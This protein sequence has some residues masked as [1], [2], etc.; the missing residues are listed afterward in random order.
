MLK[1]VLPIAALLLGGVVLD[2]DASAGKTKKVGKR[3]KVVR[4]ER[5]R[6]ERAGIPRW[7][8][9]R[10]D[11]SASCYGKAPDMG[12]VGNVVDEIGKKAKVRV[13]GITP[14]VDSCGNTISWEITTET[15][16]GDVSQSNYAWAA[17]F[18]YKTTATTRTIYNNGQIAIPGTRG[19]GIE[20]VWSAFDDDQDDQPELIITYY[21]CDATGAVNPQGY[22]GYCMVY[23]Q[24]TAS[25]GFVE[26]RV[27][28]VRSC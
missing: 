16:D 27:D 11:G 26:Q 1:L 7:C 5:G 13:T 25:G 19:P 15:L 20:S 8:Q 21:S 9:I 22:G 4:V 23:Y 17:L 18:D 3:G 14:S 6:S 24:E 12:Q 10:P 28:N 2:G